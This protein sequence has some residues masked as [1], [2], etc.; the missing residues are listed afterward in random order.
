MN[1]W[2]RKNF[3]W[4]LLIINALAHEHHVLTLAYQHGS[5]IHATLDSYILNIF[6]AKLNRELCY[7]LENAPYCT[8][9]H[10]V[11][12]KNFPGLY[13]GPP[14]EREGEEGRRRKGKEGGSGWEGGEGNGGK[15]GG[16]GSKRG[17][18][19]GRRAEG[20]GGRKWEG[21]EKKDD[22]RR[23]AL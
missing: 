8:K 9:M 19:K 11:F 17:D 3:M 23:F 6:L 13:P 14:F 22:K 18:I 12:Q 4:N 1:Q 20:V 16:E 10:T 2:I 21:W 15:E 7:D 5:S